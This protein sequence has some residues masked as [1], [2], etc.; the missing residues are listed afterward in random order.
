[1]R[2]DNLALTDE[3]L[4]NKDG[5]RRENKIV[6]RIKKREDEAPMLCSTEQSMITSDRMGI[7]RIPVPFLGEIDSSGI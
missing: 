3:K 6:I 5:E 1:M 2:V 7:V 4:A